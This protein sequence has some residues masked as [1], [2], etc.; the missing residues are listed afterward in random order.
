MIQG[1]GLPKVSA[2]GCMLLLLRC[3]LACHEGYDLPVTDY[4]RLAGQVLAVDPGMCL[5]PPRWLVLISKN[6][7]GLGPSE[8]PVLHLKG[9]IVFTPCLE[10][11]QDHGSSR[12]HENVFDKVPGL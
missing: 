4:K 11:F 12:V 6:T 1:N 9:L 7:I 2:P 10:N 8:L 5:C 3:I